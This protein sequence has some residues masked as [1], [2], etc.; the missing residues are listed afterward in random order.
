MKQVLFALMV[1][2]IAAWTAP[3]FGQEVTLLDQVKGKTE[4]EVVTFMQGLNDTELASLIAQAVNA[5][6][7]DPTNVA[8]VALRDLVLRAGAIQCYCGGHSSCRPGH[9]H[10]QG[11]PGRSHHHR[12]CPASSAEPAAPAA[13][14]EWRRDQQAY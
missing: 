8:T 7:A 1:L 13:W 5:A 12:A 6:I 10:W 4:A 14:T 11:R 9:N 2:V 3:A